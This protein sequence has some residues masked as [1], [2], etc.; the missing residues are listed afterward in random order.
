MDQPL[1]IPD[2]AICLFRVDGKIVAVRR[3]FVSVD[4]SPIGRGD[5]FYEA[6]NDFQWQLRMED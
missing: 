4:E 3:D 6:L 1:E 2:H 5:T